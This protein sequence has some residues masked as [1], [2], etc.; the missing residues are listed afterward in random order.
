MG[1]RRRIWWAPALVALAGCQTPPAAGTGRLTQRSS[2]SAIHAYLQQ[3]PDPRWVQADDELIAPVWRGDDDKGIL[4]APFVRAS[5][6]AIEDYMFAPPDGDCTRLKGTARIDW[7]SQ[8]N[9][10]HVL[11]KYQ[12]MP[13]KPP[14]QRTEG[15]EYWF[16]PFHQAPKDYPVS[17]YRNW[18]LFNTINTGTTHFY[19]GLPGTA[20]S[21]LLL[22]SE[23]DFP[24]G[25]P[26]DSF[27]L[28]LPTFPIMSSYLMFP[29]ESGFISHEYTAPYDHFT[30]EGGAYG[31]SVTA[32]I[33]HDLCQSP[34]FQPALGQIRPYASPWLPPSAAPSWRTI[35]KAGVILDTTVDDATS[36][37][38]DQVPF[39]PRCNLPG[40]NFPYIYSGVAFMEANPFVQGGIPNGMHFSIPSAIQNVAPNI[41][42]VPGGNGTSCQPFVSF[43]RVDM[44]RFC[45]MQ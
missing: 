9:T 42:P 6:A 8:H 40:G 10:V 37:D 22:G 17:G 31:P 32:F 20:Q 11:L 39:D 7:D 15:T 12:G 21:L 5:S 16:N 3:A 26:P 18:I 41:V 35:L 23:H 43:P 1:Q 13:V 45:E 19:Y 2:Q 27:T 38:F 14:V 33:P 29:D 4:Y 28:D 25:P 36:C 34:P 24:A 44:P 30:V